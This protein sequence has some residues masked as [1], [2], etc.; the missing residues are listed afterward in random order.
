M[1]ASRNSAPIRV[2]DPS[3][4]MTSQKYGKFLNAFSNVNPVNQKF[5]YFEKKGDFNLH[6][7]FDIY[8]KYFDA[9][10]QGHIMFAANL[11]RVIHFVF[12]D[13][14]MQIKKANKMKHRNRKTKLS[15]AA[16][17][18]LAR[19]CPV[20]QSHF[21]ACFLN[22]I[23]EFDNCDFVRGVKMVTVAIFSIFKVISRTKQT[24]SSFLQIVYILI[25][26]NLTIDRNEF[27]IVFGLYEASSFWSGCLEMIGLIRNSPR[28]HPGMASVLTLFFRSSDTAG[29]YLFNALRKGVNNTDS[30]L[31]AIINDCYNSILKKIEV[32][33]A[34]IS[35]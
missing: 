30:D 19:S 24:D 22:A 17:T 21:R 7:M 10:R 34:Y 26:A 6:E 20:L 32:E 18:L 2:R 13:Y 3:L 35:L 29:V 5:V 23:A 33:L 8:L 25:C 11:L 12:K 31:P 16:E 1:L 14:R 15:E 9:R 28:T 4:M 27:P